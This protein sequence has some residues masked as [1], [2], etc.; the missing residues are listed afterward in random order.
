MSVTKI[1]PISQVPV[2][3]YSGRKAR[4][5]WKIAVISLIVGLGVWYVSV[6]A[7][8]WMDRF[9]PRKFRVVEPGEIY[10]S[11]QIDQHLIRGVLIDNKIGQVVSLVGDDPSDLD[12]AAER[13]IAVELG[14]NWRNFPLGGD[15]TGNIHAYADALET[16]VNSLKQGKP[17]LLHCSS[18]AQRSNG[19]TYFYRVLIQHWNPEQAADEMVRNGHVPRKNPAL[20]EYL[21]SNIGELARILVSKSIIDHVPDPL[22]QIRQPH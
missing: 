2:G 4:S 15:G 7:G 21:N 19:A 3:P 1:E 22:P 16:M 18:G 11:G 12:A 17:V 10:A 8:H 9:F 6:H 5:A 13:K 20:I 14:I